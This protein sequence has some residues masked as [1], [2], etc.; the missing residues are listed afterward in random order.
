VIIDLLSSCFIDNRPLGQR[1]NKA[2]F[3]AFLTREGFAA[4]DATTIYELRCS[5]AH[6]FGLVN[7]ATSGNATRKFTVSSSPTDE[8][9]KQPA[10]PWDGDYGTLT[11]ETTTYI[12][13]RKVADEV[14]RIVG[15]LKA[16]ANEG[17]LRTHLD[18]DQF[19]K[20]FFF[21]VDP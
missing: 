3:L 11:A 15:K 12:N 17:L 4:D 19:R 9:I 5:F 13:L 2:S 7:I 1:G 10:T 14:E 8:M 6:D 16:R 20:R 21:R 18:D